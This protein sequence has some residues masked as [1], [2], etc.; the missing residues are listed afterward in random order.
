MSIWNDIL[1]T[2]SSDHGL[3]VYDLKKN[4]YIKELY[5]KKY[6]HSEWVTSLSFL[7]D[8]RLLSSGMDS[9]ICLWDAKSI[10]C[11]SLKIHEGSI[12]KVITDENNIAVSAGYD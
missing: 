9:M 11:D 10:K 8:G 4:S 2:G 7:K 12:S 6:G 1:A 5:S 3:R